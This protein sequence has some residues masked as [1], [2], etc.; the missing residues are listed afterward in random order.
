MPKLTSWLATNN[1]RTL[2][3][4]LLNFQVALTT[5]GSVEALGIGRL[6]GEGKT[7]QEYPNM[8]MIATIGENMSLRRSFK[9]WLWVPGL[10]SIV[11]AQR[12]CSEYLG[13]IGVLVALESCCSC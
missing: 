2:L 8:A 7:A 11:C 3:K 12:H 9:N 6:I 4:K 1:S 5:N 13:K 10:C